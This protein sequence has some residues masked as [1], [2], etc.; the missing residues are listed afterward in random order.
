MYT[1]LE[2][3]PISSILRHLE[4]TIRTTAAK[5]TNKNPN[6]FLERHSMLVRK[7]F[8]VALSRRGHSFSGTTLGSPLRAWNSPPTAQSFYTCFF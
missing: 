1:L 4:T 3:E 2:L 6:Q 8:S 5:Q 7:T